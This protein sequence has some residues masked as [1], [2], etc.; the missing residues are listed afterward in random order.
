MLLSILVAVIFVSLISLVGIF[1]FFLRAKTIDKAIPMLVAFASGSMLG[2]AFLHMLPET[3][4]TMES[5]GA[6][7]S[8][9]AIFSIALAGMV[10]LFVLERLL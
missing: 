6:I 4:E 9:S 10:V 1:F 7:V 5:E 3:F 2:A 8:A